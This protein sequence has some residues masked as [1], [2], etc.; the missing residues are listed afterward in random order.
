M[1]YL[2]AYLGLCFVIYM[3]T[4][5]P[6]NDPPP[7]PLLMSILPI[8]NIVVLVQCVINLFKCLFIYKINIIIMK[9]ENI[10]NESNV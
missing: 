7:K 6:N 4:I 10:Q 9:D 8:I 3:L 2:F 5:L 1:I